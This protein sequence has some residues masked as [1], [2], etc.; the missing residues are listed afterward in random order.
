M[1]SNTNSL[2]LGKLWLSHPCGT[3]HGTSRVTVGSEMG[4]KQPFSSTGQHAELPSW[5]SAHTDEAGPAGPHPS[6]CRAGKPSALHSS[7]PLCV[8]RPL[9]RHHYGQ[10]HACQMTSSFT[11]L[12]AL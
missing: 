5:H 2:V 7:S 6:S 8:T 10:P 1:F 9:P 3:D 11:A 4:Q 12:Q